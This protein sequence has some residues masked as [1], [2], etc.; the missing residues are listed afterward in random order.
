VDWRPGASLIGIAMT[1]KK[2]GKRYSIVGQKRLTEL[3]NQYHPFCVSERSVRRDIK[4][5]KDSNWFSVTR[6]T[7][8]NGCG[9]RVFTSNMYKFKKKFFIWLESLEG[10]AGHL[11]SFF[12]RPIKA[13]NKLPKKP[14]SCSSRPA[15]GVLDVEIKKVG[16]NIGPILDTGG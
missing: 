9:K 16:S 15:S 1:G 14:A 2:H 11:F 8:P 4:E 6:R 7:R 5:L 12:R 3:V 10:L 13:V